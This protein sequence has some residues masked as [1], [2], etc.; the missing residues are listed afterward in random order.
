MARKQSDA[1]ASFSVKE[2]DLPGIDGAD[3]DVVYH[4]RKI[5]RLAQEAI[6]RKNSKYVG[7]VEVS[8]AVN[9]N[10]D[11]LDYVVVDWEGYLAD[12]N[13]PLPCTREMKMS[14]IPTEIAAALVKLAGSGRRAEE[15]AQRA[16]FPPP[17]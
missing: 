9:G 17:T 12:D 11:V 13:T 16:T 7:G 10:R 15:V 4:C 8:D 3:P 2:T 1:T 6:Y 5:G 14:A